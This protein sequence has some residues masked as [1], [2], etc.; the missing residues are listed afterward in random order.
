MR[1]IRASCPTICWGIQSFKI[2]TST[3]TGSCFKFN[4]LRN[5]SIAMDTTVTEGIASNSWAS[6]GCCFF[7][8]SARF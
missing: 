5:C 2:D 4:I 6:S 8:S 1:F 7:T 3:C